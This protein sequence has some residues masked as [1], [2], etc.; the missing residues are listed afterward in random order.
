MSTYTDPP[1]EGEIAVYE[2]ESYGRRFTGR[3][4]KVHHN[5]DGRPNGIVRVEILDPGNTWY[6]IGTRVDVGAVARVQPDA[7]YDPLCSECGA[8]LPGD[9]TARDG[10]CGACAHRVE[11]TCPDCEQTRHDDARTDAVITD[12]DAAVYVLTH[13]EVQDCQAY[14]R[15]PCSRWGGTSLDCAAVAWELDQLVSAE[16][17]RGPNAETLDFAMSLVVD[18]SDHVRATLRQYGSDEVRR[19]YADE[20]A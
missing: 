4:V 2:T 15:V 20:L 12:R 16:T 18:G 7:D 19:R 8:L 11:T 17:G 9:E 10:F 14:D 5:P 3:T 1:V 6:R 13:N